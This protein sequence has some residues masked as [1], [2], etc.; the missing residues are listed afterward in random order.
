LVAQ[1]LEVVLV[2]EVGALGEVAGEAGVGVGVIA[3]EIRNMHD[4]SLG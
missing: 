4:A 2:A 3:T 1:L